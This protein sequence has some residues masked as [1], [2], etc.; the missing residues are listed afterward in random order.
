VN[1]CLALTVVCAAEDHARLRELKWELSAGAT[2]A[3]EVLEQIQAGAGV[4]VVTEGIGGIVAS[5]RER[6]PQLRVVGVG[7]LS[8]AD[9]TVES[10]AEV[11]E[12]ILGR[13]AG[14]PPR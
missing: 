8:G 6:F 1:P 9:V 10:L 2:T 12:A 7:R 5:V 11:R 4:L 14:A 13:P 3:E